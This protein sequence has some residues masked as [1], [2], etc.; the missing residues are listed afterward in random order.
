MDVKHRRQPISHALFSGFVFRA[1]RLRLDGRHRYGILQFLALTS[2]S[3][4]AAHFVDASS[5]VLRSPPPLL[6]EKLA[7][8]GLAEG[9]RSQSKRVPGAVCNAKA[10]GHNDAEVGDV[11]QALVLLSAVRSRGLALR[12]IGAFD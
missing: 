1:P 2:P 3:C 5:F 11:R 7:G 8:L 10:D 4:N 6:L 12:A 9:I